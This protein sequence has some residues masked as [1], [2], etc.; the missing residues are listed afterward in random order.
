MF[1]NDIDI[2]NIQVKEIDKL[3]QQ[4]NMVLKLGEKDMYD[5]PTPTDRENV[6]PISKKP[7]A[8]Y[9]P[10]SL[11]FSSFLGPSDNSRYKHEA[12]AAVESVNIATDS[13]QSNAEH[14]S[15]LTSS[16]GG[17]C[18]DEYTREI[19]QIERL[20]RGKCQILKND[21]GS[22]FQI[23]MKPSDPD[24]NLTLLEVNLDIFIP[25]Q[26]PSINCT[27]E[28][29]DE[30]VSESTL[31]TINNAIK[32]E[33]A[34][35]EGTMCL[36][37]MLRWIDRNLGEMLQPESQFHTHSSLK[38]HK[39]GVIE[40][41]ESD[42]SCDDEVEEGSSS[43]ATSEQQSGDF[44]DKEVGTSV[45]LIDL[46]LH[47][48]SHGLITHNIL[49]LLQCLRCKTQAEVV[50]ESNCSKSVGCARC[51]MELSCKLYK[52]LCL[53]SS[54]SIACVDLVG[55]SLADTLLTRSQIFSI[56]TECSSSTFI[57]VTPGKVI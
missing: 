29:S 44:L 52:K 26:Y 32:E 33:L 4:M 13:M 30:R 31:A 10:P 7:D 40:L 46:N 54:S 18:G 16:T 24:W 45:R 51:S 43:L 49:L 47:G 36:R 9:N 2:I 6:S 3:R 5:L 27:I 53:P 37:P 21:Q 22:L 12:R 28:F 55:C 25:L 19:Q 50:V 56:C 34:I 48:S 15:V 23:M 20:Y 14:S 57:G 35:R 1:R 11:T 41:S 38:V 8:T 39:K 17:L 42:E